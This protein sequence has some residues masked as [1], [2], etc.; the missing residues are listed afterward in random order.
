[1][2][3]H[4]YT[5]PDTKEE[6]AARAVAMREGNLAVV[7]YSHRATREQIQSVLHRILQIVDEETGTSLVKKDDSLLSYG[8]SFVWMRSS[9]NQLI[10]HTYGDGIVFLL[11][12]GKVLELCADG[13]SARGQTRVGDVYIATTASFLDQIGGV[14]ALTYYFTH[15]DAASVIE[16]LQGY[17]STDTAFSVCVVDY[18]AP[19][20][21]PL[22]DEKIVKAVESTVG[23]LSEV[24]AVQPTIQGAHV[25]EA[26]SYEREALTAFQGKSGDRDKVFGALTPFFFLL[27]LFRKY[28]RVVLLMGLVGLLAFAVIMFFGRAHVG[29]RSGD[30]ASL[31]RE[32]EL[33]VY[34]AQELQFSDRARAE[35]VLDAAQ[36]R[37]EAVLST[38][39]AKHKQEFAL[40]KQKIEDAR[41]Q[42]LGF[43]DTSPEVHLD[44]AVVS[45]SAAAVDLDSD[46]ENVYLLDP[47]RGEI[48]ITGVDIRSFRS[49]RFEK[50]KSARLLSV[51]EGGV[52]VLADEGV[53]RVDKGRDLRVVEADADWQGIVDMKMYAG[54]IYMLDQDASDV[55]KYTRF[56]EDTYGA[57]V[58]YFALD[59]RP[60]LPNLSILSIDGLVYVSTPEEVR[61]YSRGVRQSLRLQFPTRDV[62]IG[63]LAVHESNDRI[64]ISD[65]KKNRLMLFSEEG[66]FQKQYV[67]AQPVT[68]LAMTKD[69]VFAYSN[70]KLYRIRL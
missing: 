16:M 30:V 55:Y 3:V 23:H 12:G 63:A 15:M 69:M 4:I 33:N 35:E 61:K 17:D 68:G 27:R 37:L 70:G 32:I 34:N 21:T 31:R 1:M 11:R 38:D 65:T 52:Y 51:Y 24:V 10:F 43:S 13:Q 44:L 50:L 66:V 28:F 53:L 46:G 60:K 18:T 9:G 58:S 47:S 8:I 62:R 26:V 67:F 6:E 49:I 42:I 36:K 57:K 59:E 14:E 25:R 41:I 5:T 54:N 29:G 45:D 39:R 22:Q 64:A 40:L 19:S 56:M 2:A 7:L 20:S 48:Y